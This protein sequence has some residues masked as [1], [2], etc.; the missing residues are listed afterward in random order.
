MHKGSIF[1]LLVIM[2]FIGILIGRPSNNSMNIT[3]SEIDEFEEKL[4]N[5]EY[6]QTYKSIKPND[7][8]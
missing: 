4:E 6:N 3:Q 2:L 7:Y 1:L 5:G 8:K